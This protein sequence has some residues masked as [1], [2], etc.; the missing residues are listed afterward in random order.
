ML[1]NSFVSTLRITARCSQPGSRGGS[2]SGA[3]KPFGLSRLLPVNAIIRKAA[4]WA[5]EHSASTKPHHSSTANV[6]L[7]QITSNRSQT[8]SGQR[9]PTARRCRQG[10]ALTALHPDC[11]ISHFGASVSGNRGQEMTPTPMEMVQGGCFSRA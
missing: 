3:A 8:A 6:G 10:G 4:A 1:G 11:G 7:L 5:A 9:P 2:S